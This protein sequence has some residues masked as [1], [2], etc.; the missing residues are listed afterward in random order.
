MTN[1]VDKVLQAEQTIEEIASEL[2]R[3][4]S[5]AD[6]LANS[7]DQVD[8]L[9]QASKAIVDEAG[10]FTKNGAEIIQR[11]SRMD[12][13]KRLGDMTRKVSELHALMERQL[14]RLNEA[15]DELEERN[16]ELIKESSNVIKQELSESVEWIGERIE[17]E[18]S[19]LRQ[20]IM[21]ALAEGREERGQL[22]KQL[23]KRAA[24]ARKSLKYLMGLNAFTLVVL[25]VLAVAMIS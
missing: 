2:D 10:D 11:L 13:E 1:E 6:L 18:M 8:A 24:T 19:E 14:D 20:Q 16:S 25:L 22:A 4:K 12:L 7:Q 21:G 17:N 15:I 9:I 3:M 5:A 23:E